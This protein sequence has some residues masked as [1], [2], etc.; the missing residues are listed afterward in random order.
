MKKLFV[1]LAMAGLL[2]VLMP[3]LSVKA[4]TSKTIADGVSIGSVDVSGMTVAQAQEAVDSYF[5]SIQNS[6]I[7]FSGS[8]DNIY[9]VAASEIGLSWGNRD[10]AEK[11]YDIGHAG[12]IVKR[13]KNLK[14]I[15]RDGVE[16]EIEYTIDD[17]ALNTILTNNCSSFNI[18]KKDFTLVRENGEFSVVEGQAGSV[19]DVEAS[20]TRIH[21][22]IQNEW[23][24]ADT[25]IAL[26]VVEDKPQGSEEELLQVKDVL[27][28]FST[29]YKSSG[30]ARSANV[31]NGCSL[32]NGTTIY[33]GE[34]FSVLETITPFTEE[35]GYFPAGSYLNGVVVESIGGGIC[36]VSSTLYNA[37][38]LSELEVT[39]R[40]NHS[41]IVTYVSP[42]ADAAIAESG[43]KNFKFVNSTE[44]P[45]YIEGYCHEKTITFT[46][47]GVE[48]RDSNRKVSY[49]S[50]VLS[51]TPAG[52]DVINV[53]ASQPVG[54]VESQ[55]AHTGYKAQLLKIVTVDGVEVSR[56]AI[57]SS[58]YQMVPRIVTVGTATS[59]PTISAQINAAIATGDGSHVV[60]VAKA[61]A[62]ANS[63]NA[64]GDAEA[65]AAAASQVQAAVD[66]AN[67]TLAQQQ[68]ETASETEE[69]L[70]ADV[71]ETPAAE[72]P[73]TET[74]TQTA[75]E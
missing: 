66:A 71:T 48:T 62:A 18:E 65:A 37:V 32:I 9:T 3:H 26:V 21:E 38:L 52:A 39:E 11:A 68:A 40:H 4:A 42:S 33:P 25:T 12:N 43:G 53:D 34:E 47:Y 51:T 75:G 17:E 20:V 6:Q 30:S 1:S 31:A 23:N 19:I 61:L 55:S 50:E 64:S 14:D 46:I 72:T 59:D 35:N 41:M 8:G 73:A 60:A 67:A 49:E 15:A 2:F 28:T 7:T 16:F 63:A 56:E 22:Y 36:Q 27:G 45:I 10:V 54:Y 29:S 57:N 24:G 44:Y 69:N 58:T 74:T 70:N 5:E 13:Y